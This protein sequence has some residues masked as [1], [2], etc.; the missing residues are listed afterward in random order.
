M[1]KR[2]SAELGLR[3]EGVLGARIGEGGRLV[4]GRLV[5][6]VVGPV[7]V[8]SQRRRRGAEVRSGRGRGPGILVGVGVDDTEGPV[9]E[10]E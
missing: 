5:T 9:Q 6:G 3:V 2:K 7:G 4:V 1:E 8:G 10:S